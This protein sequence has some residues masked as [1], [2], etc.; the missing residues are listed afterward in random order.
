MSTVDP[1]E[2]QQIWAEFCD[3]LK[4]VGKKIFDD[5]VPNDELTIAEGLRYLTRI[6]RSGI[7]TSLEYRDPKFPNFRVSAHD[8]I[9]I[10]GS[11]PDFH[12]L[13]A[14]IDGSLD[15]KISGNHGTADY[16][17][18]STQTS[19]YGKDRK[20]RTDATIEA[21][22]LDINPDGSFKLIISQKEHPG[23]WLRC[24]ETSDN[25]LVRKS[26]KRRDVEIPAQLMITRMGVGEETPE[27][28][29]LEK[30][31]AGLK[32]APMYF[33]GVT[34]LYL[35]QFREHLT[36]PPNTF[37]ARDKAHS[38]LTGADPKMQLLYG[39]FKLAEDECL[40]IESEIPDCL[41]WNFQLN[42]Y[43][44]EYFDSNWHTVDI[45]GGKAIFEADGSVK[46]VV[47]NL[48]AN[49]GKRQYPSYPNWLDTAGHDFGSM[50]W[51]WV[52]ADHD[53]IPQTRVVKLACLE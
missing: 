34:Q 7:E 37:V 16:L 1:K 50:L 11:N 5:Q 40:I 15:Y 49:K 21:T 13:N 46:I 39:A 18:F 8:T 29:S 42:N 22:E 31:I 51:R 12:Y 52:S 28:L 6:V 14:V 36:Y 10:G 23:N 44:M 25:L 3:G 47:A 41:Y 2:A 26:F 19:N 4:A 32:A 45:N 17:A 27:P 24:A 20:L 30:V 43:W 35:R 48:N 53:P 38:I 9:K 33:G